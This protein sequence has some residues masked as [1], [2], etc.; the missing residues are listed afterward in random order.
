MTNYLRLGEIARPEGSRHPEIAPFQVYTT[1]DGY[2]VIAAG[3][4]HLFGL[5]ARAMGRPDLLENPD[6]KTNALRHAHVEQLEADMEKTLRRADDQGV[7]RHLERRGR[8]LRP[9]E[10]DGR[11][12]QRPTNGCPSHDRSDRRS[13]HRQTARGG[14]SDQ[15]VGCPER[16]DHTPPP[17]VDGDRA[18]ILAL[19]KQK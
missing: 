19:L 1:R 9:G 5:M 3:N 8:P 10:F 13:G 16:A 18:A 4:D 2:L 12:R 17:A 7:A 11:S 15:N 6:Y 14:Q